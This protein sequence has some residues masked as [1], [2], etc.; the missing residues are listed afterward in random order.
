M[1]TSKVITGCALA[2]GLMAFAPQSQAL[3]IDNSVVA[4]VNVKATVT[5]VNGSS[6][7]QKVS[8]SNKD[9]LKK[10]GA[11]KGS[12]LATW[13]G[14]MVVI[15]D[16]LI[17]E[18]LTVAGNVSFDMV[19]LSDNTTLGKN[20][21][22]KYAEVGTYTIDYASDGD[23]VDLTDNA[24]AFDVS[25]TYSLKVSGSAVKNGDQTQTGKFTTSNLSGEAYDSTI[26]Q[27]LPVSATVSGGGSGKV[28]VP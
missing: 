10:V 3:V 19:D 20:G 12:K 21:A 11:P 24:E 14:D 7:V 15:S 16:N 27:T 26:G 1:K 6:K 22:F 25:G 9:I 8:F 17:W 5:Y 23:L 4:P 18:D 2:A 13:E 28:L